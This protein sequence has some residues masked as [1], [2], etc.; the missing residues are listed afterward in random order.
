MSIFESYDIFAI[1][2]RVLDEVLRS[3]SQN[4][5]GRHLGTFCCGMSHMVIV[6][7]QGFTILF[8]FVHYYRSDQHRTA[9]SQHRTHGRGL[10]PG[11]Y[12][13]RR[14]RSLAD[15]RAAQLPRPGALRQDHRGVHVPTGGGVPSHTLQYVLAG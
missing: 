8:A 4:N 11:H 2:E 5:P 1:S 9:Q 14:H 12:G 3:I 7:S 10:V 15:L 6:F 13:P